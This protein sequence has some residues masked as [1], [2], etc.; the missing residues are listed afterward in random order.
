MVAN[1][2]LR[3]FHMADLHATDPA[4]DPYMN[5]LVQHIAKRQED[6]TTKYHAVTTPGDLL[7]LTLRNEG[8]ASRA[9][10]K[11]GERLEAVLQEEEHKDKIASMQEEFDAIIKKH[12]ITK[13]TTDKDISSEVVNQ[14]QAIQKRQQ[15]YLGSV[16]KSIIN[17]M[18]QSR[19][20]TLDDILP[21]IETDYIALGK[22]FERVRDLGL[23]ILAVP[24]NHDTKLAYALDVDNGGPITFVDKR[25]KVELKGYNG[26]TFT[27]QG[28]PNT[29]EKP[30][31]FTD[32]VD[33]LLS[34]EEKK[35]ERTAEDIYIDYN[36]GWCLD[37]ANKPT[38]ERGI[39][40]FVDPKNA[41][42]VSR[43][44]QSQAAARK[45][46]GTA[47]NADIYLTHKVTNYAGMGTGDVAAEYSKGTTTV[48]AGHEHN[49]Q[50]GKIQ[51]V[52]A[53]VNEM[54]ISNE[55]EVIDGSEVKVLY[56][57]GDEALQLNA[58]KDFAF[59]VVYDSA[60]QVEEVIVY[61]L[62]EKRAA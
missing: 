17:G 43:V 55:T 41:D 22:K 13:T 26:E 27:I 3:V 12:E 51:G 10:S 30:R 40:N 35:E 37:E 23:K 44:T 20:Y 59:E 56:F 60:K 29:F 34:H 62:Q 24:G 49:L 47:G 18:I 54:R 7:E 61:Q 38:Y 8:T 50:I 45:R 39:N 19:E 16:Q 21:I 58:G 2:S 57:D 9:F 52:Q 53:L 25:E 11:V 31:Q 46:L 36:L 1:P 32:L 5:A 33:M 15:E 48:L 28:D 42:A 4:N 6:S 14:I